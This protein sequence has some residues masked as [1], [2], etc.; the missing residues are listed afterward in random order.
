M[1]KK[2]LG[3]LR[4]KP[5]LTD[6]WAEPSKAGVNIFNLDMPEGFT[7]MLNIYIGIN[8]EYP[9]EGDVVAHLEMDGCMG[10]TVLRDTRYR[11]VRQFDG[12]PECVV[13]YEGTTR[14]EKYLLVGN[15]RKHDQIPNF[16]WLFQ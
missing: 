14:K 15:M 3:Y 12:L 4:P 10:V 1:F 9:K 2:L 16:W 5:N 6:L 13:A 8:S 11:V 7:R